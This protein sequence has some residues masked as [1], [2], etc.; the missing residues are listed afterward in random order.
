MPFESP[1]K[2][3]KDELVTAQQMRFIYS[4]RIKIVAVVTFLFIAYIIFEQVRKQSTETL[5]LSILVIV[6]I[7]LV[8]SIYMYFIAPHADLLINKDWK[9]EYHLVF[10]QNHLQVYPPDTDRPLYFPFDKLFMVIENPKLLILFIQNE[11]T[12]LIL[13]RRLFEDQEQYDAFKQ[14][15]KDHN[16]KK[17][18]VSSIVR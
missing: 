12:Y 1:L 8:I 11:S 18:I 17:W 16:P 9:K 4:V 13:P 2:Y 6:L 10:D 14:T 7:V 5:G 15:L 3:Q